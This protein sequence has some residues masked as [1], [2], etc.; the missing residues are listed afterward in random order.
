[1]YFSAISFNSQRNS[2]IRSVSGSSQ[3]TI[4]RLWPLE[5]SGKQL[6]G[7]RIK[8][9]FAL[10]RRAVSGRTLAV[11]VAVVQPRSQGRRKA[12]PE[13]ASQPRSRLTGVRHL[14]VAVSVPREHN[15]RASSMIR[16]GMVTSA[17]QRLSAHSARSPISHAISLYARA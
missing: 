15:T 13:Y 7:C 17:C 14:Y 11:V 4:S 2:Q 5:N 3:S 16:C 8:I 12:A 10:L 6:I 9:H 1:M